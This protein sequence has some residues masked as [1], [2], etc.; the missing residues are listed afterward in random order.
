VLAASLVHDLG[1]GDA[2]FRQTTLERAR[3]STQR[4][5]NF[6]ERPWAVLSHDDLEDALVDR[7]VGDDGLQPVLALFD[8]DAQRGPVLSEQRQLEIAIVKFDQ[9]TM[10]MPISTPRTITSS[11]SRSSDV[12]STTSPAMPSARLS[13][14]S[15]AVVI[16][17]ENRIVRSMH[18]PSV[19]ALIV[20][21]VRKP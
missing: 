1:E 12:T 2:G 19:A 15:Y 16:M 7:R 4:I 3:R 11:T 10:R 13:R 17:G 18:S 6:F 5:G 8:G 20:A 21:N 9:P 14:R